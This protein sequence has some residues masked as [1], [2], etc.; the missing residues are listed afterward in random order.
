MGSSKLEVINATLNKVKEILHGSNHTLYE[1]FEYSYSELVFLENEVKKCPD[2]LTNVID[3]IK[4]FLPVDHGYI[5]IYLYSFLLSQVNDPKYLD[6]MISFAYSDLTPE[7]LHFLYWQIN[8]LLFMNPQFKNQYYLAKVHDLYKRIFYKYNVQIADQLEWIPF[9]KRDESLVVIFSNQFILLPHGPT[10]TVLDRCVTLV[11]SFGKK[12]LLIN[13][14]DP[15]REITMPFFIPRLFNYINEYTGIQSIAYEGIY[16]P[17]YQFEKVM[18]NETEMSEIISYIYNL[19]PSFVFSIGGSNVT[20]DL[21]SNFV[22]VATLPCSYDLPITEGTFRILGRSMNQRDHD[23]LNILD[24]RTDL[25]IESEFTFKARPMGKNISR[26]DFGL[27]PR[28]FVFSIVGGRLADEV[29]GDFLLFLVSLLENNA[30][31]RILF[32]GLFGTYDSICDQ[33]IYFKNQ[34]VYVGFQDDISAYLNLSDAYL[35]PIRNGGGTSAAEA[36]Y[37]GIPVLTLPIGDVSYTVGPEFHIQDFN[38]VEIYIEKC[39]DPQFM[40]KRRQL[41]IDRASVI[42]DSEKIVGDLIKDL[43]QSPEFY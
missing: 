1:K 40:E 27:K 25:V 6:Q 34:S 43:Y 17:F 7:T 36:L 26:L 3:G 22:P 16:I 24:E 2:N 19:K 13:T 31:I 14:A 33:N 12:I 21:C 30:D 18:P 11:R 4:S 35:N 37:L 38:E 41:A 23:L 8:S 10:Q 20:A 9:S 29:S 39:K 32:I 42:F 5:D 15:P 28:H